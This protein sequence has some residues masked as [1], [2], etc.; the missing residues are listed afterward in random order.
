[1][2]LLHKLKASMINKGVESNI[3][4]PALIVLMLLILGFYHKCVHIFIVGIPHLGLCFYM[5]FFH[6]YLIGHFSY[7]L[8]IFQKECYYENFYTCNFLP[9]FWGSCLWVRI[10]EVI[11]TGLMTKFLWL[12]PYQI[13]K[14][15]P[16]RYITSLSGYSVIIF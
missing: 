9:S 13:A 1:M 4:L 10:L 16:F 7:L 6:I 14:L 11:F 8:P 2:L 15:Y 5:I 12:L 3:S